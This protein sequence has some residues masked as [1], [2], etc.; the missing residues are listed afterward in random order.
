MPTQVFGDGNKEGHWITGLPLA[1]ALLATCRG[2]LDYRMAISA[3]SAY[4]IFAAEVTQVLI[5]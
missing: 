1:Y 2:A 5:T 4:H 3:Y